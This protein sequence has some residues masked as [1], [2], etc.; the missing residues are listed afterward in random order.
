MDT[1]YPAM[2]PKVRAYNDAGELLTKL[3]SKAALWHRTARENLERAIEFDQAVQAVTDGATSVT[4]G[5]TT[6]VLV[7]ELSDNGADA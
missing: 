4:I 1:E 7:D 2:P 6:Y 3:G 5:R